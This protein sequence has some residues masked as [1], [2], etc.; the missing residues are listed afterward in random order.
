VRACVR[1]CVQLLEF[2]RGVVK[3]PEAACL[4]P[5][6]RFLEQPEEVTMDSSSEEEEDGPGQ[7]RGGIRRPGR[8]ARTMNGAIKGRAVSVATSASGAAAASKVG[9]AARPGFG[10]KG[11]WILSGCS[12]GV[13]NGLY[14]KAVRHP[15]GRRCVCLVAHGQS[16]TP[17]RQHCLTAWRM[18]GG[19]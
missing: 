16:M 12:D 17:H 6:Q 7:R 14:E 3:L 8:V 2:L 19:S 1:A 9:S 4:E 11:G 5:L 13:Y 18:T 10:H 15:S